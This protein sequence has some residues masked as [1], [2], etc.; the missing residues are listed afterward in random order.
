MFSSLSLLPPDALFLLNDEFLANKNPKKINGGIGIY[1]APDGSPFVFSALQKAI[2][3]VPLLPK[4]LSMSGDQEFCA[5][6][7]ETLLGKMLPENIVLQQSCG[8][9]HACALLAAL[10]KR[11]ISNPTLIIATPTWQNHFNVFHGFQTVT[12]SHIAEG[13]VNMEGYLNAISN[14]PAQSVLLLHGGLTHNPTGKNLSLLDV[15]TVLATAREKH[16][17]VF[18]DFA[19]FGFGEGWEEDQQY[20]RLYLEELEECAVAISFSKN[21]ALYQH[22]TGILMLKT[23]EKEKVSTNLQNLVRETISNLPAFGSHLLKIVLQKYADE[24]KGE[25]ESVRKDLEQRRKMLTSALPEEYQ[26]LAT[27][28]GMFSLLPLSPAQITVLKEEWGIFLPQ[29]GRVNIGG[30]RESDMEYFA[31]AVRSVEIKPRF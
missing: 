10:V 15:K 3:Q 19:Y 29:S 21:A 7:M 14:A 28:K 9:T 16:I 23:P 25:V 11:E 27:D 8:G 4:Y 22:R 6:A 2:S 20:L 31:E 5:L 1:M 24:W 13:K 30:I 18:V 26:F 17:F 12:F